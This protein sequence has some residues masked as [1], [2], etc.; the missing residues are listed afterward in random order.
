MITRRDVLVGCLG[1]VGALPFC[2]RA[3][4]AIKDQIQ[5]YDR[6]EKAKTAKFEQSTGIIYGDGFDFDK[7]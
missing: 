2:G 6:K 7:D 4:S 1:V 5:K 3:K